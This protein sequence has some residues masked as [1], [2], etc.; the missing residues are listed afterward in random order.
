M[1]TT[2]KKCRHQLSQHL[3]CRFCG[4]VTCA[5]GGCKCITY[6]KKQHSN[7]AKVAGHDA[8]ELKD[9]EIRLDG[10]EEL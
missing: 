2:C 8:A 3:L 6:S 7:A 9:V 1:S 4:I 10:E 5:A